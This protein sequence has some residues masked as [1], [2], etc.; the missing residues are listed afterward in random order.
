MLPALCLLPAA[1]RSDM[2]CLK[3]S[4]QRSVYPNKVAL[5]ALA[6]FRS[7]GADWQPKGALTG[8]NSGR[9]WRRAPGQPAEGGHVSYCS[10]RGSLIAFLI[11]AAVMLD[12]TDTARG[13]SL[14]VPLLG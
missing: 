6:A 5:F 7:A 10:G 4:S 8:C 9:L 3:L 13:E 14:S 2:P 11:S 12:G 1:R